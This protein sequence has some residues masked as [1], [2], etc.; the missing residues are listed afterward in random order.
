M[1]L[2]PVLRVGQVVQRRSVATAVR[3][4][5]GGEAAQKLVREDDRILNGGD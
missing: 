1:Q 4:A 2:W 5:L 3:I